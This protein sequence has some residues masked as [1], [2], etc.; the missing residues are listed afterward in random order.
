MAV[1]LDEI[2]GALICQKDAF[3]CAARGVSLGIHFQKKILTGLFGGE[4]L[5]LLHMKGPGK[6]WIQSMPFPRLVQ[7]IKQTILAT[8]TKKDLKRAK[9]GK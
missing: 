6:V 1:K 7:T 5:F 4:G 8:Q 3:L 9:Q 2:G